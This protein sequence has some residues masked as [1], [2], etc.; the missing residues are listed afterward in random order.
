ML[1]DASDNKIPIMVFVGNKGMIQIRSGIVKNIKYIDN[2]LNILDKDFN[3]H[4]NM[5]LISESWCVKKPTK[6]GDVHSLELYD[7]SNDLAVS[8]FGLRKPGNEELI[9]WRE[10]IKAS[11][12]EIIN[13]D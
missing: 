4:L 3:L 11:S 5:D 13:H 12:K 8:F 10:L 7:Q 1:K 9:E 2:W 6:D